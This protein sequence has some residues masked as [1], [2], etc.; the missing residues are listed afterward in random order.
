MKVSFTVWRLKQVCTCSSIGQT[1][2]GQSSRECSWFSPPLLCCQAEEDRSAQISWS[3][4]AAAEKCQRSVGAHWETEFVHWRALTSYL[5]VT[6]AGEGL[7]QVRTGTGSRLKCFQCETGTVVEGQSE[8]FTVDP[9]CAAHQLFSKTN[10][11]TTRTQ[12]VQ[13]VCPSLT[14]RADDRPE[15]YFE[16]PVSS[17]A[18]QCKYHKDERKG[19]RLTRPTQ[20]WE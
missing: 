17:A 14:V 11:V 16:G 3:Q 19:T 5:K 4:A 8:S 9:N 18:S 15:L 2:P 10:S 12:W 7:D 6:S 20:A 1:E 13:L